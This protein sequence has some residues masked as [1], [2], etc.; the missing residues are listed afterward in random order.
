MHRC[1]CF[2]LFVLLLSLACA[3]VLLFPNLLVLLLFLVFLISFLVGFLLAAATLLVRLLF[4]L[5][6]LP[7][8]PSKLDGHRAAQQRRPVLCD[9]SFDGWGRWMFKL[10]HCASC[11]LVLVLALL[12]ALF[13][14]GLAHFRRRFTSDVLLLLCLVFG[15]I[16]FDRIVFGRIIFFIRCLV[17]SSQQTDRTDQTTCALTFSTISTDSVVTPP[18]ERRLIKLKAKVAQEHTVAPLRHR[19]LRGWT[20]ASHP[21]GRIATS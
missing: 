12:L 3:L 7:L 5:I 14:L 1:L 20:D 4:L 8:R 11:V 19:K 17:C 13:L 6:V 21:S 2:R 18:L 10:N 15:R 9:H 16:L